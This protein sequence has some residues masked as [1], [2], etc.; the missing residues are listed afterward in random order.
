[1]QSKWKYTA[2]LNMSLGWKVVDADGRIMDKHIKLLTPKYFDTK[3]I[4]VDAE[5]SVSLKFFFLAETC[6]LT[7]VDNYLATMKHQIDSLFSLHC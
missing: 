2:I 1:M 7:H 4:C 5:V 6:L 3:F